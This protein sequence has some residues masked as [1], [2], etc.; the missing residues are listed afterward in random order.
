MA[1]NVYYKTLMLFRIII[2]V[3]KLKCC[4]VE[5]LNTSTKKVD[6]FRNQPFCNF[7]TLQLY[8][9]STKFLTAKH[10]DFGKIPQFC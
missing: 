8:N 6:Y 5:K 2:S 3:G 1:N 4:K 9:I 10:Q 7:Q